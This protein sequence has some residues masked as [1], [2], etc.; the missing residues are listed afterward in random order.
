MPLCCPPLRCQLAGVR[1]GRKRELLRVFDPSRPA[2]VYCDASECGGT[3]ACLMQDFGSGLQPIAFESR[4]YSP[5]EKNYPV[6]DKEMLAVVRAL[7]VWRHY[8]L[9]AECTVFT[10]HHSLQFY[11]QKNVQF[12]PRQ[13]RWAFLLQQYPGLKLAYTPGRYNVVAD[14]LSRYPQP[15]SAAQAAAQA[16]VMAKLCAGTNC[17]ELHAAVVSAMDHQGLHLSSLVMSHTPDS[18]FAEI[19]AAYALDPVAAKALAAVEAGSEQEC[20]SW[21]LHQGLLFFRWG[22]GKDLRLYVPAPAGLPP[23]AHSLRQRLIAEHH[24]APIAGHLGRDRTLGVLSRRFYWLTMNKD[25]TDYVRSCDTC[26]RTKTRNRLGL[27]LVPT[28]AKGD[29]VPNGTHARLASAPSGT[30]W[31]WRQTAPMP[32]PGAKLGGSTIWCHLMPFSWQA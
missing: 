2:V 24:D 3:G 7:K 9:E 17:A 6:H 22:E 1:V 25:V 11:N 30:C 28:G 32:K 29:L 14:C 8:L 5:A 20:A 15:P 16:V 26:Q 23:S 13:Q 21:E 19:K 10:D 27:C 12:S 31:G 18:I 4:G